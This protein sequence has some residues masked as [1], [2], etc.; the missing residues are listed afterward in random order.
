M[1]IPDFRLVEA[2]D[3]SMSICAAPAGPLCR[4]GEGKVA[5]QYYTARFRL[6][7]S[8]AKVLTIVPPERRPGSV[9]E[10]LPRPAAADA[11]PS[12]KAR[13]GYARAST[14]RRSYDAQLDSLAAAGVSRVFAEK[15]STRQAHRPELDKAIAFGMDMRKTVLEVTLVAHEHKRLGRGKTVGGGAVTDPDMLAMALLHRTHGLSLRESAAKLVI[16][17]GAKSGKHPFAPPSCGCSAT[18]TATTTTTPSRPARSCETPCR[19]AGVQLVAAWMCVTISTLG[20]AG[21]MFYGLTAFGLYQGFG[22][23]GGWG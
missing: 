11:A 7:P 18:T 14:A 6:V 9:R 22:A 13:I 5:V 19:G 3:C 10:G 20:P 23:D 15:V 1:S 2:H 8:L 16:T 17:T 4:T 21:K 12:G